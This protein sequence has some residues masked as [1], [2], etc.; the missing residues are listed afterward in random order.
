MYTPRPTKK[1]RGAKTQKKMRST[2][3]DRDPPPLPLI[4]LTPDSPRLSAIPTK[5]EKN[6][7]TLNQATNRGSNLNNVGDRERQT[8][9][10]RNLIR[11]QERD[12]R[13]IQRLRKKGFTD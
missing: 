8:N 6:K 11:D 7:K 4:R 10:T 9:H 1:T 3:I 2:R 12:L 13:R 5:F